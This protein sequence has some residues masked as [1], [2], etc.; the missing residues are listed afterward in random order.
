MFPVSLSPSPNVSVARRGPCSSPVPAGS[1][2]LTQR[3]VPWS[4]GCARRRCPGTLCGRSIGG[5]PCGL[6]GGPASLEPGPRAVSTAERHF[7]A[8]VRLCVQPL[9]AERWPAQPSVGPDPAVPSPR[10]AVVVSRHWPRVSDGQGDHGH[11]PYC[12]SSAAQSRPA[13]CNPMGCGLPGFSVP[14]HSPGACSNLCPL[15]G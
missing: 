6:L 10:S 7:D 2:A 1:S 13:L 15:S 9:C 14:R 11:F 4:L 5:R 8:A 3:V 12:W